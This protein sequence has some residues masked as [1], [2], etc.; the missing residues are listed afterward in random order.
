MKAERPYLVNYAIGLLVVMGF[1]MLFN[2]VT[3]YL[4]PESIPEGILKGWTR[5]AFIAG[6]AVWEFV[7]A[8]SVFI[9][10][11]I[12]YRLAVLSMFL[13][14]ILTIVNIA[15]RG[16]GNFDL[17]MQTFLAVICLV[18]LLKKETRDFFKNWSLGEMPKMDID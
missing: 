5:I 6:V 4:Y 18:F 17:G 16:G 1:H 3:I 13:I 10:S 8:F 14:L 9:G 7:M 15:V 2:A 12:G 11:G